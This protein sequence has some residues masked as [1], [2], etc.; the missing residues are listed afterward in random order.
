M[1]RLFK[2]TMLVGLMLSARGAGAQYVLRGIDGEKLE[3]QG[4]V[5]LQEKTAAETP[6][7]K[8]AAV[9]LR[10][11][12]VL[13]RAVEIQPDGRGNV[14]F[15]AT[16][17][18]RTEKGAFL[19]I[20]ATHAP[21]VLREQL[22][23]K[24]G[25]VVEAV[26]PNSPADVAGLKPLDVIEKLDDQWLINPAQLAGLVRMQKPGDVVT[27]T[28]LHK[29]DRQT[30]KAKLGEREMPVAGDDSQPVMP[31]WPALPYG[32][33]RYNVDA[34]SGP[35][36]LTVWRQPGPNG[37]ETVVRAVKVIAG[38]SDDPDG[39]A[40]YED[41]AL[42]LKLDRNDGHTVLTATDKAG[43][44]IFA[45]PIDSPKE[46]EKLPQEVRQRMEKLERLRAEVEL[47]E[48][49]RTEKEALLDIG[50]EQRQRELEK[51]NE[52][53]RALQADPK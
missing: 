8:S 34:V 16:A 25:L 12:Q 52:R 42:M 31:G 14:I 44:T 48:R 49:R 32:T 28:I 26:E 39:N 11:T 19:G 29:G 36:D 2:T 7:P 3:V 53:V 15:A 1:N 20:N 18:L 10:R 37:P 13:G 50:I 17:P 35:P 47:T 51:A 46:R 43:K 27:L 23:L 45:G 6:P 41:K 4:D 5:K 33:W 9:E 40:A 38:R 21:A 22:K 30:L 24:A